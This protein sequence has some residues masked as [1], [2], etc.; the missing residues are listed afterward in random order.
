MALQNEVPLHKGT[1]S[2]FKSKE[3]KIAIMKQNVCMKS[4][5]RQPVRTI[6]LIFLLGLI[7]FA[8]ISKAVEYLVVQR[9]TDRLGSYYRSIGSLEPINPE[10]YDVSEGA[11]LVKSSPYLAFEDRLRLSSGVMEGLYNSD[12]NGYSSENSSPLGHLLK[13]IHN[14]DMWIYGTLNARREILKTTGSEK[15]EVIG[16]SLSFLIDQVLAGYPEYV[17]EGNAIGFLFLFDGNEAAIPSIE[18]MQ[19]GQRYLIRGWKDVGFL[20]DPAWENAGSILKIRPLDDNALWYLSVAEGAE[21][22][23]NDPTLA[24]IKNE[25]DILN[26]NQH[27]LY[28]IATLDM[29]A[30]PTMQE[31]AHKYYL[32]EGRW[33]NRQDD[34]EARKVIVIRAGLAHIRGL[35]LGDKITVK[36]RGLKDPFTAE[37]IMTD[38]DRENWRSYPTYEGT[39]EIVGIYDDM[40]AAYGW[41]SDNHVYIPNSTLPAWFENHYDSL[42]YSRYNF[43]L[44][45]CRNQEA[46]VNENKER[47]ASLGISLSFVDNNCKAFWAAVDPLRNSATANV[48]IFGL[49]LLLAL[50][51]AVFLYL[52]QRRRDYAILQALG[53]PKNNANHQMLLPLA[54]LGVVGILA[55]GIPSWKYALSKAAASL[56]TLP[57]PAGEMPSTT[58]NLI[59][60]ATL[61]TIILFLLMIFAWIGA[62][63]IARNPVLELLQGTS[64]Q[65]GGK[66]KLIKSSRQALSMPLMQPISLAEEGPLTSSPVLGNL[67]LQTVRH[68]PVAGR[69]SSGA[70][71]RYALRSISRSSFRS[72]LTIAVALGFVL[73]LGWM[74]W[75]MDKNSEA[76]NHLYDTTVVDVDIVQSNYTVTSEGAG[77]ID[78]KVVDKMM[79]SGFVQHA[80]LEAATNRVRI[81]GMQDAPKTYKVAYEVRAFD[82]PE[83]FF[84]DTLRGPNVEYTPG[85]DKSMFTNTWTRDVIKK[86]FVPAVFPVSIL[87]QFDLKL[88]DTLSLVNQ[89]GDAYTYLIAGQY[90]EQNIGGVFYDSPPI[91][92]PLSALDAMEGRALRYTVAKFELDPA[93]NRELPAFRSEMEKMI[94]T[95]GFP[96]RMVFWDEELRTVVAPLEKNLSLL[97]V[98]YPVTVAVSVLIGAGLCLLLV[99]QAVREA[100][101][102]RMLGTTKTKVRAMLTSEHLLLSLIGVIL[103]IVVLIFVRKDPGTL[104]RGPVIFAASLYLI[105]ALVGA[106]LGAIS[107]TNKKPLELLQVKE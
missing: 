32:V 99:L 39:F 38:K 50:A 21:V 85:W 92:L 73:A 98:L 18:A 64:A 28:V 106:I 1:A 88:G 80:Y 74:Q 30:L 72:L 42:E 67:I 86:T 43:V 58:L 41:E 51:L 35:E 13:G 65:V 20:V 90:A 2:L 4:T 95:G 3:K 61:C 7:S 75:M 101:L 24:D 15:T 102:L 31:S 29:S 60:L 45:T 5:L 44:D 100:A 52:T 12:I 34:L 11:E 79:Q 70:L 23:F 17:K 19:E 63:L 76:V 48:L 40:N 10:E 77:I 22:D 96:L 84:S 97:E 47:L 16:Y 82:Q 71:A 83:T 59:Y 105:G 89:A 93:K 103:G 9:E 6:F 27:A 56:A 94:T 81:G 66:R 57:T 26:E 69:H 25:I 53:V 68:M 36:L 33:L 49:V 55:G 91:L 14:S 104:L 78:R 62:R 54:L 37:Y 107:V 8:F 87:A 46:F